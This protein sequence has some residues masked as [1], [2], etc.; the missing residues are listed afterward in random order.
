ELP[1][2][3]IYRVQNGGLLV[4]ALV[5]QG[6]LR[7]AED[8]LAPVD[9]QATD[10]SLTSAILRLA[11]GRL[12]F[13][14]GRGDE[15]LQDFLA[16]GARVSGGLVGCPGFLPWRSAASGAQLALGDVEAAERLAQEEVE[17]A[18]AFGAPRALGVA[19]RA[20]GLASGGERG[21]LLLREALAA[22]ERGDAVLE[23]ARVLADLGALLR[24]RNRRVEARELLRESLDASYRLGAA[25]L[26]DYAETELPPTAPPPPRIL[27]TPL[28]PLPAT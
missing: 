17:L 16:V 10:G 13:A 11:R 21:E 15:S 14:Q 28:H 1:A 6:E 8:A 26:A 9:A 19:L 25:R 27:L 23:R 2:P 4:K 18:E 24:R 5:E 7:A 22:F 20:A 12:R 3:P